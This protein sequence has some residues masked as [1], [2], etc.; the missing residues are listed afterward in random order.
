MLKF[1]GGKFLPALRLLVIHDDEERE[2]DYIAGAEKALGTA[3]EQ[4]WSV[5]S[6]QNDWLRV[7]PENG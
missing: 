5:V 3:E 1:A 6:I 7:F 2:F 4:D